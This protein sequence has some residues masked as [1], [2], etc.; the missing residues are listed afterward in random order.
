MRLLLGVVTALVR[1]PPH[2]PPPLRPRAR[3]C[4]HCATASTDPFRPDRPP[5]EPMVINAIQSLL[6]SDGSESGEAVA[7]AA[8]KVR[9][10]CATL[11]SQTRRDDRRLR[12]ALAGSGCRSRLLADG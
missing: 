7:T 2:A 1:A 12:I 5:I 6:A 9:A 4:V 11:S 10:D 3:A 8:L